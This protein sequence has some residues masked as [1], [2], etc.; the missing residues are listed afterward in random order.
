MAKLGSTVDARLLRISPYAIRAIEQ[1][2]AAMGEGYA[3][4]GS[5]LGKTITSF[6]TRMRDDKINA[7][8]NEALAAS[9]S[10]N[11]G[12]GTKTFDRKNFLDLAKGTVPP[13]AAR[14][15][16][17]KRDDLVQKENNIIEQQIARAL[18]QFNIEQEL[19]LREQEL[20]IKEEDADFRKA[21]LKTQVIQ[22][23]EANTLEGRRI[24][25]EEDALAEDKAERLRKVAETEAKKLSA[26]EATERFETNQLKIRGLNAEF[27]DPNTT[28][29]RLREI[30]KELQKLVFSNEALNRGVL[31]AAQTLQY[32]I[33]QDERLFK[34]PELDIEDQ[35]DAAV[36]DFYPEPTEAD[37]FKLLLNSN[38]ELARKRIEEQMLTNKTPKLIKLN[39]VVEYYV[40]G[41]SSR[42]AIIAPV[43][44]P[45]SRAPIDYRNIQSGQY[46]IF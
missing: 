1:G 9:M 3:N 16:A 39:D 38:P 11:P 28:P 14:E 35:L 22:Q 34:E 46:P 40:R 20:Q 4:L 13:K 15:F 10:I 25:V 41:A 18:N 8:L 12:D 36:R 23:G 37:Q 44:E 19:D 45:T 26:Q 24:T 43:T 2:G 29:E 27:E 17:D 33:R 5:T 30:N 21:Q 42:G 7:S 6:T 32:G 31:S